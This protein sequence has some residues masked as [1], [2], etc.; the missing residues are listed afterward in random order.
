M[1]LARIYSEQNSELLWSKL[2]KAKYRINE[3]FSSN[4][5]GC[6]LFWHS[7]HTV[8]EHFRLGVKFFLGSRSNISFWKDIW[9]GEEPLSVRFPTLFEKSS[10]TDLNIAQAYTKEGWWIP[11]RRNLDQEDAQ[12]WRELC[13]LVEEIELEDAP[14]Q[15]S[16]RLELSGVFSTKSL[17]LALCKGSEV[18]LTK[19][20][21]SYS[22]PLKIK[23]F[24][25]QLARGR[26]PSNDQIQSRGGPS[27]GNCALCRRPWNVDH[28]FQCCFAKFMWSGVR[29]MFRGN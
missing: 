1:D 24:T 9:I 8:K 28:I 27:E 25:W 19:F 20:L 13:N 22:L 7:I 21:W 23:V 18:Q 3:I 2:L 29:E 6:S 17:Y 12:A 16:W 10:D 26:L 15:I 5:V 14:A 11:F 4:P